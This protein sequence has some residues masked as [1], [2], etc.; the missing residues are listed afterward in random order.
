MKLKDIKFRFTDE[1]GIAHT[2]G[3]NDIYGYESVGGLFGLEQSGVF[4]RLDGTDNS[5]ALTYN[6]GN[7]FN[8]INEDLDVDL[9]IK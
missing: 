4:A 2:F 6:S 9:E 1:K 7:G 5:I 8:G 3:W